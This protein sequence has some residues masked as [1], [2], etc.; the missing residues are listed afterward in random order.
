MR[1]S[2]VEHIREQVKS[3]GDAGAG[4]YAENVRTSSLR[5][6]ERAEMCQHPPSMGV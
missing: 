1:Q 5:W 3:E 4:D 2:N 6:S